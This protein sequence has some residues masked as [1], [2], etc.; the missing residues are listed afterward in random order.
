MIVFH[1]DHRK[2]DHPGDH[3]DQ[4]IGQD[5]V[6]PLT[7]TAH[8][9]DDT[10]EFLQIDIILCQLKQVQIHQFIRRIDFFLGNAVKQ[11]P[12][13]HLIR[14]DMDLSIF[15]RQCLK[16]ILAFQQLDQ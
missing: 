6:I 11:R 10:V 7:E 16:M 9:I 3:I 15:Q 5:D 1:P 4:L 8:I 12:K 2:E 14:I 13:L